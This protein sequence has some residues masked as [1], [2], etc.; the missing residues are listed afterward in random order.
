M[1]GNFWCFFGASKCLYLL[2]F[3]LFLAKRYWSGST[4]E[5]D[6]ISGSILQSV[7]LFLKSVLFLFSRLLK[8]GDQILFLRLEAF[9][10]KIVETVD[11]CSPFLY[12]IIKKNALCR[13]TWMHNIFR[14]Y[15]Q[16]CFTVQPD[17]LGPWAPNWCI[18]W[19]TQKLN[20]MMH[21]LMHPGP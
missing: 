14:F 16:C 18:H 21:P 6:N 8:R 13:P 2:N 19:C 1:S 11:I 7:A 12:S 15:W 5:V 9:G 4:F 17:D 10:C 20:S 3:F